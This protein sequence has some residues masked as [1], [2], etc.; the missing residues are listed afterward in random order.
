MLYSFCIW[1]RLR[2]DDDSYED[3]DGEDYDYDEYYDRDDG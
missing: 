3:G 2:F 1:T